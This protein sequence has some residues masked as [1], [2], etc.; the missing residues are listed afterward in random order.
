M[1]DLAKC[2]AKDRMDIDKVDPNCEHMAVSPM[3]DWLTETLPNQHMAKN[4]DHNSNQPLLWLGSKP[5]P[6]HWQQD[7]RSSNYWGL[8][9]YLGTIFQE[10]SAATLGFIFLVNNW[11]PYAKNC[12]LSITSDRYITCKND[13]IKATNKTILSRLNKIVNDLGGKCIKELTNILWAL[14]TNTKWVIG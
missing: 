5:K 2:I 6:L 4:H 10:S 9:F 1:R 14:K 13:Q 8:T 7:S 3:R 11:N 12:R